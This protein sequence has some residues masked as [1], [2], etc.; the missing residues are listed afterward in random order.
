MSESSP[1]ITVVIPSYQRAEALKRS[2]RFWSLFPIKLII[3]DGSINPSLSKS[4]IDDLPIQFR[5]LH[6]QS[7]F[8]GRLKEGS[9]F[10]KTKYVVMVPDD[11][12]MFFSGLI[13]AEKLLNRDN[14]VSAVIG[15]TV[16]FRI[17]NGVPAYQSH[18]TSVRTMNINAS[19]PIERLIQRIKSPGNVIFYTLMRAEV[20]V[21]AANFMGEKDFNCPYIPEIQLESMLCSYGRISYLGQLIWLRNIELP[22]IS[23]K[24]WRRSV[25][26]YAW[27]K[28]PKNRLEVENLRLICDK[29]LSKFS[30]GDKNIRGLDFLHLNKE[31]DYFCELQNRSLISNFCVHLKDLISNIPLVIKL[32]RKMKKYLINDKYKNILNYEEMANSLNSQG[33]LVNIDEFKIID[34]F[35][36]DIR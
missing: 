10:V 26:F 5:Y 31:F 30:F 32:I 22:P 34:S 25:T 8:G 4:E 36:G 2:I 33:V 21:A 17:A 28:N 35:I 6:N 16:S 15:D 7:S 9:R 20:F 11:E 12:F 24:G 23:I 27:L 18:Y 13:E 3:L 14:L 19:T 1:S 29:H